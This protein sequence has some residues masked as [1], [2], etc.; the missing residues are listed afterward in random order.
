M[1]PA[2][3]LSRE[4]VLAAAVTLADREGVEALAVRGLAEVLGVHPTS[5]YNHVASKEALLDGVVETLFGELDLP[6]DLTNWQDWVR[7]IAAAFRR[8]A[9]AHPGAFMVLTRRPSVTAIALE[10]AENGL[11]A[12]RAA[13]FPLSRAV[14]AVHGV[15]LAVLGLAINEC[16]AL[17]DWDGLSSHIPAASLPHL[18]AAESSTSP[19]DNDAHWDVVVEALIAGLALRS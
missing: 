17:G 7:E 13:G 10:I 19:E 6:P 11:A 8:L 3:R 1:P 9:R 4:R 18:A 12:F 2:V 14:P 15:S 16:H 5:L